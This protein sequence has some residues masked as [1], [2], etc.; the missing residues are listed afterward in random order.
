MLVKFRTVLQ[1]VF[2]KVVMTL[3]IVTLS[4][5]GFG[6]FTAFVSTDDAV[7][8][9]VNGEK[10]YEQTLRNRDQQ[11]RQTFLDAENAEELIAASQTEAFSEESL[12]GLIDNLV[13][14]QAA[15][16][17][18][19]RVPEEIVDN[20]IRLNQDFQIEGVYDPKLFIEVLESIGISVPRYRTNVAESLMYRQFVLGLASTDFLLESEFDRALSLVGE[21]RDIAWLPIRPSAFVDDLDITEEAIEDRF[22]AYPEDYALPEMVRVEYIALKEQAI[23]NALEVSDEE[24]EERY[25]TE[26]ESFVAEEERIAFH[27]L[28]NIDEGRT[29]EQAVAEIEALKARIDA[30][31]DFAELAKEH[32]D[33]KGTA[34]KGGDLGP[35]PRGRYV[36][37]FEE[38]LWALEIGEYAEPVVSQF[39]VHLIRLDDI[40][41]SKL[42]SFD[43]MRPSLEYEF[44]KT[45]ATERFVEARQKMAEI[46]YESSDL[47][48]V[49]EALSLPV[50]ASDLFSRAGLSEE[51]SDLFSVTNV[52]IS[53]FS[54]DVLEQGYNSEVLELES[55]VA[56]ILRVAER[57][58]ARAPALAEVRQEIKDQLQ[59]IGG[60]ERAK[61]VAAAALVRLNDGDDRAEVA[62]DLDVEW[63]EKKDALRNASDVDGAVLKQAFALDEPLGEQG[64]YVSVDTER[65]VMLVTVTGVTLDNAASVPETRQKS[66]RRG[67]E[68]RNGLTSLNLVR[69]GLFKAADVDKR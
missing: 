22:N 30:G 48:A 58:L 63:V 41:E 38:A 36:Q 37:P 3:I 14:E 61:V 28:L 5:F 18:G 17:F 49:S 66:E 10:I 54:P 56:L 21:G 25:A 32:S 13:L 27:I 42:R 55:G 2:G 33:D 64:Y 50:R 31:E 51:E 7:V 16:R 15:D 1:G 52:L 60:R 47:V 68:N 6:A 39:G 65:G 40:Q 24:L 8:A 20:K 69:E 9:V 11:R 26:E 45:Q 23:E 12:K 4:L 62:A 57:Q 67:L 53:A 44:K 34:E 29:S 43:E 46:G 59:L 19:I 35:A